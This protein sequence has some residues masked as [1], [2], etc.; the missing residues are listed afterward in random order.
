MAKLAPLVLIATGISQYA[1]A[2]L[3]VRLFDVAP[4]LS[5]GWGRFCLGGLLLLF[6][7]HRFLRT[8]AG[9]I[10]WPA[11]GRAALFG[12]VLGAM[13]LTFYQSID[14][15]ALG[16]AVALEFLGPVI[17]AALTGRGWRVR[18]GIALACTG[19][20]LISWVGVDIS[21]PA[22]AIGV[23]FAFAAGA[24]W[25]FYIWMGRTIAVSEHSFDSLV[26]AL[27]CAAVIYAPIG[28][29]GIGPVVRD[30]AL[31]ALL[32]CVAVMSSVVPY[33]LDQVVMRSM[34]R[35]V[36]ALLN[37]LLPVTSLIVGLLMLHQVPTPGEL[38]GLLFVSAAVALVTT[39]GD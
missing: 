6:A 22:V 8:P 27:V 31:F 19:V 35:A 7:R 21:D 18:V 5:V 20:F 1:G 29:P 2:S 28:A 4:A 10:D 30:T 37:S 32:L 12:V 33:A 14:R 24:M 26:W 16:T 34:S 9:A 17:L 25:A 15:I 39:G 23:G 36:F 3:A 13:N 11:H 38:V